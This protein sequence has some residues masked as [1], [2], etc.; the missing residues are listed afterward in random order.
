[1]PV[2]DRGN[3]ASCARGETLHAPKTQLRVTVLALLEQ[4]VLINAHSLQRGHFDHVAALDVVVVDCSAV[5]TRETPGA[6]TTWCTA[7]AAASPA[8]SLLV[9]FL[10]TLVAGAR[11]LSASAPPSSAR[12]S[13]LWLCAVA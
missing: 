3:L 6:A 9:A 13:L 7:A 11:K 10:A 5:Y 1:M 12:A 4:G 8:V 2:S